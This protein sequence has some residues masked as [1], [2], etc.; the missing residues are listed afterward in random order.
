MN[1][2]RLVQIACCAGALLSATAAH[3]ADYEA[4]LAP[5]NAL[6][7]QSDNPWKVN[8]AIGF[9]VAPTYAYSRNVEGTVLPLIDVEWRERVFASTQRGIGYKWIRTGST[10]LGP[11]LTY[12]FG[13]KESQDD[14]LGTADDVGAAVELGMFW[15]HYS[16][17]WRFNADFKYA[18]SG[19]SGVHGAIGVANGGMPS[20]NTSLFAGVE[21]HYASKQYNFA[22]FEDGEHAINDV[23]PYLI[24]VRNLSD[25]M[26]LTLDGRVAL[27]TGAA[28]TSNL[29]GSTSYSAGATFGK[30]F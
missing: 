8:L 21:V 3:A 19:H 22:Y 5:P 7:W 30:R 26:Y 2:F 18:A 16:G 20:A 1:L 6:R 11:R 10:V 4:W 23:T 9:G 12:D 14:A 28:G 25:G 24:M 27:I 17:S 15:T 29:T 13:R